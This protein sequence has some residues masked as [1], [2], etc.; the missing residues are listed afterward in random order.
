MFSTKWL[1]A[2]VLVALVMSSLGVVAAQEDPLADVDPTGQTV[3]WWHNHS[4]SREEKLAELIAAFNETNEWGITVEAINQG[5]YDDIRDKMNAAIQSGELPSLVVGYQNDQAFYQQAEALVDLNI[6]VNSPKWGLTEEEVADFYPTFWAQDVH[7]EYGGQRLGF[8]PNRSAALMYY[9]VDWLKE[10]GYDA[11]PTTWAAFKEVSC[12]ATDAD[13]GTFGVSWYDSA[14]NFATMVMGLG[15][16][17]IAEDG[18]AYTFD[19]PE[20]REALT[21]L[22]ELAAAGCL[23]QNPERFG[24]QADFGNYKALFTFGSSSGLPF[25]EQ[26]VSEGAQGPFEWSVAPLPFAEGGEAVL[27]VYGG[28]ISMPV[29]TAEQQLAAWLFLKWFTS[30]ENQA[31]W[32]KISGYFPTRASTVEYIQDYLTENP[33]FAVAYELLST[34]KLVYEPQV[35]SYQAVRDLM[36][37]AVARAIQGDDIE[38]I[39]ADLQAGADEAVAEFAE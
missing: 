2:F 27:D 23:T 5:S 7:P 36:D 12:A 6:Y 24:N 14:S 29:T 28:S 10:L 17:I 21:V 16:N 19:T 13:A 4:G 35:I 1:K 34:T 18:S 3:V 39:V 30:A 11:P 20:V 9:N 33:H 22:Q 8:P 31:E 15:S 37:E 26:A 25:Y 32:V 38:T